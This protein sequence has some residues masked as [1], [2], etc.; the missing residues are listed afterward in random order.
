GSEGLRR[1]RDAKAHPAGRG[2]IRQERQDDC[3]EGRAAVHPPA[4]EEDRPSYE[5]VSRARRG[6]PVQGW[7]RG[8][9]PGGAAYVE[10]EALV[11]HHERKRNHVT[12]SIGER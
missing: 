8:P 4:A 12:A 7:R 2:R 11:C 1:K 3:R 9:H 5:E 10:T 6:E